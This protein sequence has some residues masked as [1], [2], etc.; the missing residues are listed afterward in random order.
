[1]SHTFFRLFAIAIAGILSLTGPV[2]AQLPPPEQEVE[3]PHLSP[4]ACNTFAESLDALVSKYKG[5]I[6][7]ELEKSFGDYVHAGCRGKII[8]LG[9][10]DD[11]EAFFEFFVIL[12]AAEDAPVA[13]ILARRQ[14]N[15]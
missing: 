1:M 4:E 14:P 8:R 5:R 6:S 12:K 13:E 11:D 9:T 3:N 7:Q 10:P 2:E 15:R